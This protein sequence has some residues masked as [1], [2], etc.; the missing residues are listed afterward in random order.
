MFQA[1]VSLCYSGA[2]ESVGLN[3]ISTSLQ[4]FLKEEENSRSLNVQQTEVGWGVGEAI[5]WAGS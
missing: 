3:D 5:K 4:V 2:A 1:I